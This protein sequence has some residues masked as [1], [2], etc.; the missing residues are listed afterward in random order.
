MCIRDRSC[1]GP[2]ALVA[3]ASGAYSSTVGL[4]PERSRTEPL[5]PKWSAQLA[6]SPVAALRPAEAEVASLATRVA[7]ER[8]MRLAALPVIARQK[9]SHHVARCWSGRVSTRTPSSTMPPEDPA[10]D[11]RT[12]Q[13]VCCKPPFRQQLPAIVQQFRIAMACAASSQ[14]PPRGIFKHKATLYVHSRSCFEPSQGIRTSVRKDLR[15]RLAQIASPCP[16]RARTCA[17]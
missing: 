16:F 10:Q 14:L 2:S 13:P 4:L 17:V 1:T 6:A 15:V 11:P 8:R 5:P 9:K 7:H 3:S 12:V